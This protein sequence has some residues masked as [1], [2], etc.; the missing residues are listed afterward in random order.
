MPEGSVLHCSASS[1]RRA[2]RRPFPPAQL[3]TRESIPR[4]LPRELRG[5]QSEVAGFLADART[6]APSLQT[7][8]QVPR[9]YLRPLPATLW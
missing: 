8:L 2:R 1:A 3:L 5:V 6:L 4:P 9:P 7:R